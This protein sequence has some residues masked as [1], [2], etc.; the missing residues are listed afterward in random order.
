[1]GSATEMMVNDF[2]DERT[3]DEEEALE[4]SED[5]HNELSNL[6]KE[7]DMPL[8]DLLAMYGYGDP[9]TE[10][11]NS[12]DHMLLPSG[13]GD[14][15]TE[16]RYSDKGDNDAD[17]DDDDDEADATSNEPDLKQFYTEML[18][19]GKDK[20]SSLT[21][22]AA[23]G[24]SGI[25]PGSRD[26]RKRRIDDDEDDDEDAEVEE[27]SMTGTQSGSGKKT[28]ASPTTDSA[29][30]VACVGIVN[31]GTASA[32]DST[33]EEG[34]AGGAID[35]PEDR[36]VSANIGSGSS[37]LLRSVSRPQSE[38]EE[39]DCDYSPDEEDWKKTIM[40][41]TDYQAAIP[42]G[43]CRYDDA[44]PYENEDKMLWDPSHISEEDTEEFLERA[45][46]PAVKGGSL[47]A[48]SHIR[49][50]EQALYL[51][52]Q[53]GYNL[54]EALRRRR[55]NVLP[56]T[57]AVSL[58]SEE[59]CHNFESGL[60]TY[61][62]D[63]HLIQKNKVRTRSVGELVQ[64]YYLW[65]KTERHDIFTY[66]ARLE[67]KKYA[68][69]PG[70]T[71]DYMDRFLEEQEGVRDRSSSPNVH[72]LLY[73]DVKRQRSSTSVTN[74]DES[75]STDAWDGNAVDPL[76]DVNGPTAPPPPPPP[77]PPPLV[78]SGATTVSSS[79]CNSSALTTPTYCSSSTRHS[80]CLSSE[81]GCVN[82]LTWSSLTP[83]SQPTSSVITTIT[84][85][86]TT[87]TTSAA[88]VTG[89]G[90]TNTVTTSSVPAATVAATA[91][92]NNYYHQRVTSSRSNESHDTP[93]PE[94]I[95]P[96]L[97]P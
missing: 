97:P 59:E 73:G 74:N 46:L 40:V 61:G 8:K 55:M 16:E 91:V 23:K 20:A 42:E 17:D 12:S 68:L 37:R 18:V 4:G 34:S 88:M 15:E 3:L 92:S 62:K 44:L 26:N 6:Q 94:N 32:A 35:G 13:S 39:D 87:T 33:I 70:I 64:F 30:A 58:W 28:R 72:C 14:P 96:H 84:I 65:K 10:N 76:A 69:H 7:G 5:S 77:P 75:K 31:L 85:N 53:C 45:Q 81:S 25:G 52:L 93:S 67:K 89:L 19:K 66:K 63:F 51:L 56:P 50:D 43:L 60:R 2:D 86:T 21:G 36:I 41:G 1:M 95:L 38:E 79:I 57:D 24:N 80:D 11:S 47:P 22:S 90:S 83:R 78:T 27:C 29:N 82:P 49:D 48:G 9:S 71:R 54:E